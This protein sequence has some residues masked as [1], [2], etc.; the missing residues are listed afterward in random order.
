MRSTPDDPQ[1][2]QRYRNSLRGLARALL[3]DES[4]ADDVVQDAYVAALERDAGF[5]SFPRAWLSRV[6]RNRSVKVLRSES[7]ARSRE[8]LVSEPALAPS[9]D[10]VLERIEL[11]ETVLDAVRR[12]REPYRCCI[13][14]RFFEE[15]APTEIARQLG[16]PVKTVKSRLERGRAELRVALEQRLGSG[17]RDWRAALIAWSTPGAS[18]PF[19]AW[20]ASVGSTVGWQAAAVVAAIAVGGVAVSGVAGGALEPAATRCL[21]SHLPAGAAAAP[22]RSAP[23]H[24]AAPAGVAL[25]QPASQGRTSATVALDQEAPSRPAD[26]REAPSEE[27]IPAGTINAALSGSDFTLIIEDHPVA[28]AHADAVVAAFFE[29]AEVLT[30]AQALEADLSGRDLVVYA[31]PNDP[32]LARHA[33]RLPFRYG[34]GS[35]TASK[36]YTGDRLRFLCAVR[37]PVDREQRAVLYTAAQPEDLAEINSIFHGPTEWLVANGSE[38]LDAG[39]WHVTGALSPHQAQR[40]L[41]SLT[42]QILAV[43][44]ATHAGAPAE[45]TRALEEARDQLGRAIPRDEFWLLLNNVLVSLG[46]AHSSLTAAAPGRALDLPLR[47]LADGLYIDADTDLLRRGDRVVTLGGLP[48]AELLAKLRRV[49]PAESDSWRRVTAPKYL[50]DTSIL[51]QLD[52]ADAPPLELVVER[53]GEPHAVSVALG[54]TPSPPLVCRPWVDWS[55]DRDNGL[56]LFSLDQCRPDKHYR[57][58]LAAFFAAVAESGVSRVAIDLRANS[59]GNSQVVNEFMRYIDVPDFKDYSAEIRVSAASTA[60][61]GDY[62]MGPGFHSHPPQVSVNERH[63]TPPPFAGEL[64]VLTSAQTLSSG[65]WFAVVLADNDLATVVGEPTGSAPSAF[66]DILTFTLPESGLSF[67]LSHKRF[68]RP[69]AAA[70]PATQLEPDVRIPVLGRHLVDGSDPVLEY[71]RE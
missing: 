14:M 44:P 53:D 63:T 26:V 31:T 29:G 8:R 35:V 47:W 61:R 15:L 30:G 28:R 43:H 32:W 68:L 19:G 22:A 60:Q 33:S 50:R 48:E 46:D 9:S 2:L 27:L 62:G 55:I 57:D 17:G 11:H 16:V 21:P 67:T 69:N 52:I 71:L 56:A 18:R 25:A 7:N 38:T 58:S 37:S 42:E 6:V 41:D 10:E 70:D 24:A 13:W 20:R 39:G 4:R 34:E 51:R 64:F 12:L 54:E 5:L 23:T 40:D 3:A 45:L 36:T 65:S 49:I 59:G 1:D 66:G